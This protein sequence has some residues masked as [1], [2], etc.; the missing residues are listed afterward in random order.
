MR[1]IRFLLAALLAVVLLPSV[2]AAQGKNYP[3]DLLEG[4]KYVKYTELK[5]FDKMN[6]AVRDYLRTLSNGV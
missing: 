2:S 4:K 6:L 3:A 5:S 1:S